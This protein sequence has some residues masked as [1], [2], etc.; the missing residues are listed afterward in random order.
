[1]EQYGRSKQ[2]VLELTKSGE[3]GLTSAEAEKRLAQ[4]GRNVLQEGK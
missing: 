1:M 4:N 2:E 3:G